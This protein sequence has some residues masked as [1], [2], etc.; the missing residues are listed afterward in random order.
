MR[1]HAT[2]LMTRFSRI[3]AHVRSALSSIHEE[4]H[5]AQKMADKCGAARLQTFDEMAVAHTLTSARRRCWR[6]A[7]AN[8]D[9]FLSSTSIRIRHQRSIHTELSNDVI[10][11]LQLL[12]TG[13]LCDADKG[14]RLVAS[15][16]DDPDVRAYEGLS[17]M[18][19]NSLK[20]RSKDTPKMIG[21]AR[22]VQLTRPNDFLAVLEALAEIGNGDVLVVNTAG[23]TRVSDLS[24]K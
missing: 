7:L 3:S 16:S 10:N 23:S 9:V 1:A 19:P 21:V 4:A 18:C 8:Q 17:L 22:T 15:T 13:P 20:L 14:H 24:Y 11:R 5:S 12:S 2:V 6:Y